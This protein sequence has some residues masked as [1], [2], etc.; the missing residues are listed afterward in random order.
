MNGYI[1]FF[2]GK[3]YE[4]H[5]ETSFQAQEKAIAY[6]KPAKSKRHLVY[7][8]LAEKDGEQVTHSTASI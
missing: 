6:F 5:A 7:V 2:N 3:Q 4:V 8:H 1:A